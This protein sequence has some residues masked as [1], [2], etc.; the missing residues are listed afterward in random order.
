M[1]FTSTIKAASFARHSKR[2]ILQRWRNSMPLRW[3]AVMLVAA[4]AH[5]V[6]SQ[7]QPNGNGLSGLHANGACC[8]EKDIKPHVAQP[9]AVAPPADE[10]C[11]AG[12]DAHSA[13]AAQG[14][15]D[16]VAPPATTHQVVQVEDQDSACCSNTGS[17]CACHHFG[18]TVTPW[19]AQGLTLTLPIAPGQRHFPMAERLC[20]RP[21]AP[22]EQPPRA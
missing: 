21:C 7:A 3:L 10:N 5:L 14:A 16:T 22:P 20:L 13:P 8:C 11:C 6:E 15:L 4:L 9:V 17:S 1:Y 2:G 18:P 12:P 19:V